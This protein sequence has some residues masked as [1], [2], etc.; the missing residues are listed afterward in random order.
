MQFLKQES[1]F[2]KYPQLKIEV[3]TKFF[4]PN[5]SQEANVNVNL[6]D[7]DED[8]QLG[9][10][11]KKDVDLKSIDGSSLISASKNREIGA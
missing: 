7:S 2:K 8:E 5:K 3:F 11:A 1:A 6:S 4:Y 10:S 9:T